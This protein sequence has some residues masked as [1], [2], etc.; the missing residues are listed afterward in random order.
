MLLSMRKSFS[1]KDSGL[2]KETVY[3][4]D[5]GRERAPSWFKEVEGTGARHKDKA[6]KVKE[7]SDPR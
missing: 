1:S 6:S 7:E 3:V 2:G 4:K 5:P